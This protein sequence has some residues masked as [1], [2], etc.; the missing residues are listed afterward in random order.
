MEEGMKKVLITGGCG[1]IGARLS[2]YLAENNYAVT[3]F[4]NINPLN[5]SEWSSMIDE[6]VVG[7]ICDPN[8]INSLV[9]K[10]FDIIIHLISLDHNKSNDS[11]NIIAPINV[12]PTWNLLD[13][14]CH[15]GLGKFIYFSTQQVLGTLPPKLISEN[16]LPHPN[17]KYG[18]THLLC[19]D[20]I[21]YYNSVTNTQCINVRLS[22]GYGSPVFNE[23]NCWWLVINDLCKTALEKNKIKLKSDGSPQRDFIHLLDIC[24]AIK[25]LIDS[26]NEDHNLFNI[27]SG[28]T[29]SILELAHHVSSTYYK[30]Y[31]KNIPVI[32]PDGTISNKASIKSE[33]NKF[34]IDINKISELGY[35]P[36]ISIEK[37]ID[38]V[39][40]YI[41]N[42]YIISDN[43]C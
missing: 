17:N 43:N 18:L 15:N 9:D 1:Y 36:S 6:V 29:Y 14:F 19:E 4:D 41:E 33:K 28:R 35:I 10:S 3:V 27:A 21:N 5:Y 20:L 8:T 12:M 34:Q 24:Q 38:E 37:G 23:N 31:N 42:M 30:K 25:I 13:K 32:L 22:N 40:S 39:L 26:D 16:I 7:N 2:K 11:P